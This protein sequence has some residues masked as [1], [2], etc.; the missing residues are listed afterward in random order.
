MA[1]VTIYLDRETE[2]AMKDAVQASGLSKSK[3]LAG[4]IHEKTAQE[5]PVSVL[6]LAGAWADFPE[7]EELRAGMGEDIPREP[8]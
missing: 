8:I 3:W 5:W 1:Q 6:N 4:L 7:V 2:Q